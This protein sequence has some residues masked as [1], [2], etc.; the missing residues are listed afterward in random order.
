MNKKIKGKIRLIKKTD[1]LR[2]QDIIYNCLN[3]ACDNDTQI[4]RFRKIY[5]FDYL[6]KCYKYSNIFYIFEADKKVLG[7]GRLQGGNGVKTI[8][9][10]PEYHGQGIGRQIID[11]LE[12]F[13]R[14]NKTKKLY[15]NAIRSAIPFYEKLGYE[16]V[17]DYKKRDNRMEKVL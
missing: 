7:M 8:Y 6:E 9:V 13:A 5:S 17:K 16:K 2:C 10:D 1:L 15:L 11:R 12:D 4:I 3:V 14:K